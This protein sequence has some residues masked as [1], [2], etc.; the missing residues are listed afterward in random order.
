MQLANQS[1]PADLL[2]VVTPVSS[3]GFGNSRNLEMRKKDCRTA[4]REKVTCDEPVRRCSIR[5]C[6]D[7]SWGADEVSAPHVC[8]NKLSSESAL[9][10]I[11]PAARR[12]VLAGRRRGLRFR[13]ARVRFRRHVGFDRLWR[14][15]IRT[16]ALIPSRSGWPP[17]SAL[18]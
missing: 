16:S 3:R 6:R 5:E 2:G 12:I 4:Q 1:D 11:K 15:L 7:A 10:A 17:R 9:L 14:G 8:W 13:L 18:I